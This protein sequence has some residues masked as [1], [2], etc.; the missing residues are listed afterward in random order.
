MAHSIAG[1]FKPKKSDELYT[2]K[3][4]VKPIW[5]HLDCWAL[6][7]C[8]TYNRIPIVLCPFDTKD[9]EYVIELSNCSNWD[10]KYGHLITGE[11]F[12]TYD[13]GDWDI[14]ISNPPFSLKKKIYE[15]LFQIGKPFALLGNMMQINYEEIGRLFSEH[16]IQILSFDR[17]VSFDGNPS[18]FMSGYFCYKFLSNNLIFEKLAN[19]NAGKYHI[20]SQMYNGARWHNMNKVLH[21][22]QQCPP[23]LAYTKP[24]MILPKRNKKW[25]I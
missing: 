10:I 16:Q 5:H 23:N 9:S 3:I 1:A 19:N 13:Y 8:Q 17:R 24:M 7:F 11:D 12:F 25:N 6:E 15:R 14:C 20:P 21:M 4:L 18:S 22:M 2:P